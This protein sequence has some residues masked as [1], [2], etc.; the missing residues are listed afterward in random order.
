[1]KTKISTLLNASYLQLYLYYNIDKHDQQSEWSVI[2]FTFL[3]LILIFINCCF[4]TSLLISLITL[5]LSLFGLETFLIFQL[6][7]RGLWIGGAYW[8]DF[9]HNTRL[10]ARMKGRKVWKV[11]SVHCWWWWWRWNIIINHW[12]WS[13]LLRKGIN[14]NRLKRWLHLCISYSERLQCL[15]TGCNTILYSK[16]LAK[17]NNETEL[18]INLLW[19]NTNYQYTFNS[20]YNRTWPIPMPGCHGT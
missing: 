17:S 16:Q 9:L 8:N 6:Q 11:L 13:L 12:W 10:W 4:I 5:L 1:M 15:T 14:P 3:Y 18:N 19:N 20:H 7:Q 2:T